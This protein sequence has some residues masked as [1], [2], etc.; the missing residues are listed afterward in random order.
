MKNILPTKLAFLIPLALLFVSCSTTKPRYEHKYQSYQ[1]YITKHYKEAQR[2]MDEYQVPASITLAQGLLESGAG[3]SR[4]ARVYN[5]HFGIKC[6][7]RWRGKKTYQRDNRPN[8]CFRAYRD[9][10]ASYEDH[11][12]FL[13]NNRR[14]NGLFEL[15]IQDY[16]AW[17][18]GLK[19]AGY[20]TARDYDTRLIKLIN[21]YELYK[22]DNGASSEAK[23]I[24]TIEE[25]NIDSEV[26]VNPNHH[27][28]YFSSGLLYVLAK[29]NDTY[30]NIA[31]DLGLEADDLAEFNEMPEEHLLRKGEIVYLVE[32][33][34]C[35]SLEYR[36]HLVQN[37]ESMYDIA[38]K[39]GIKLEKLYALQGKSKD[40][41]FV[42]R[43]G[44]EIKLR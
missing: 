34:D 39:Y 42:P 18:I 11:S 13:R 9:W 17:A 35:A 6:G 12:K 31:Q 23:I 7:S 1:N 40:Y 28:V 25:N 21:T 14:Y 33:N 20:A 24:N 15:D 22:Y 29:E 3:N 4:L 30:K 2:Q 38:Q 26:L 5:N 37:G 32:K 10:R 43:V 27:Q 44:D 8:E 41:D 36:Y 19:R 16:Q